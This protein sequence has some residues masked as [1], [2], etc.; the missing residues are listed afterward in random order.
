VI[1]L[2]A[3]WDTAG[4]GLSRGQDTAYD[5]AHDSLICWIP[6]ENCKPDE[7]RWDSHSV[8][9]SYAIRP[10][11]QRGD[12][13]LVQVVYDKRA[14]WY[15]DHYVAVPEPVQHSF[16]LQRMNGR[17][18]VVSPDSRKEPFIS[19]SAALRLV[20]RSAADSAAIVASPP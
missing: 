12:S 1:A 16:H 2:L 19:Q 3:Q 11:W 8:V 15:G 17:W 9:A 6:A 10:R 7:P 20:A 18:R 13:A 5:R 14:D 4:K